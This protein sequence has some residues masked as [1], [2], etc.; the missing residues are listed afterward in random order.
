MLDH[1]RP[2]RLNQPPDQIMGGK[3]GEASVKTAASDHFL[4]VESKC[5]TDV[6]VASHQ[7]DVEIRLENRFAGCSLYPGIFITI[8]T[9]QPRQHRNTLGHEQQSRLD[10]PVT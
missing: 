9:C 8:D 10:Q 2:L 1:L 4:S 6:G 5:S 3:V 7:V